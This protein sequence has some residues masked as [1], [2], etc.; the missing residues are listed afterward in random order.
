M[1]VDVESFPPQMGGRRDVDVVFLHLRRTLDLN[2]IS[3]FVK[4]SLILLT[5]GEY[6]GE[7]GVYIFLPRDYIQRYFEICGNLFQPRFEEVPDIV[8][9]E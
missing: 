6:C 1:D 7:V 9:K 4:S 2:G 3:C 8:N 5:F